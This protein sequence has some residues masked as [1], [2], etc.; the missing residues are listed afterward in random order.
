MQD[1]R[2]VWDRIISGREMVLGVLFTLTSVVVFLGFIFLAI[3]LG[4]LVVQ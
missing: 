2:L 3:W 4:L 1:I